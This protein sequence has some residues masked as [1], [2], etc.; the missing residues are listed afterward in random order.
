MEIRV[1]GP[2]EVLAEG[3]PLALPAGRARIV[4][5]VLALHAGRTVS[6]DRLIEAAWGEDSPA[7]ARA[8]VQALVSALRR[9][10]AVADPRSQAIETHNGGYALRADGVRTDLASF[11][12]RIRQGRAVAA[13]GRHGEAVGLFRAALAL[14]RGPAFGGFSSRLLEAEAA[15]CEEIRLAVLEECI[16]VELDL[17]LPTPN[18]DLMTELRAITV[19]HPLR[20]SAQ[21]LRMIA[22]HRAGRPAEALTAFHEARRALADELGVEPG[23][24]LRALYQQILTEDPGLAPE[25]AD[26]P[27]Q[28]GSLA[29][30]CTLFGRERDITGL[31][32]LVLERR[33]VTL[34]GPPGVGK[35][36]LALAGATKAAGRLSDGVYVVELDA[37]TGPEL[38]PSAV[39][40][41]LGI[42]AGPGRPV[43]DALCGAL[44]PRHALLV[45]D[46]CEHLLDACAELADL[47]LT[48][49]PR[50]HILATSREA[51]ALPDEVIQPVGPLDVPP[52]DTMEA[53]L[54]SPAGQM[55]LDRVAARRPGF[56]MTDE[57]QAEL[58]ARI[59]RAVEGLPLAVELVAA[60]LR[61]YALAEVAARL[62][63]Q[64]RSLSR[65]RATPD[66]HRSLEAAIA[67]SHR[68][69]SPGE[70]RV[71]ARL[72]AFSGGFTL[73]AAQAV[74]ADVPAATVQP[75]TPP[76]AA[77][78]DTT[79]R[80]LVD[81]SLLQ[82]SPEDEPTRYRLLEP[83]REFAREQLTLHDEGPAIRSRHAAYFR[84][85]AEHVQLSDDA[86]GDG[87]NGAE[88]RSI[89]LR[90]S[91]RRELPNL[92]AGLDWSFGPGDLDDGLR[93]V[94][95]MSWIWVGLPGEGLQWVERALTRLGSA[96]PTVRP[97]VL[98]AAGLIHL[99]TDL[100][101]AA[102][103]G[104]LSVAAHHLELAEGVLAAHEDREA[105]ATVRWAQAELAYYRGDP[106]SA[107]ALSAAALRDT[108]VGHDLFATVCRRAQHARNLQAAGDLATSARLLRTVLR[109]CLD[110]GLWMPAVDALITAARQEADR[111][112]PTRAVTLL[113]AANTL[114]ATTGRHPAPVEHPVLR[115]L[116]G[117]LQERLAAGEHSEAEKHGSAMTAE[118]AI[119]HALEASPPAW[120]S[121]PHALS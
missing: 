53:V 6:V 111:G 64:M 29:S 33:M 27:R 48:R 56:A 65:R 90:R 94:G 99:S 34:V 19:A 80:D 67:W 14:W 115:A 18:M 20:E 89:R 45:L 35:T 109:A 91:L 113:S 52:E 30:R 102:A 44:A 96:P 13:A 74:A 54:R 110:K 47:L 119:R 1:L 55:F 103:L 88:H 82:A 118:Q 22:L 8:Q 60:Q 75:H 85:M 73:A 116:V 26:R 92:R 112:H 105:L 61:T 97:Q 32:G 41:A 79:V 38:V 28:A 68:L 50:L 3:R 23:P 5:A 39:A 57:A 59:C 78:V 36:Q 108:A 40:G 43:M 120:T 4:L 84:E 98:Y 101:R 86:P 42:P 31:V 37:V 107:A 117:R 83:I 87:R 10:L 11:T 69:L 51:L 114:R 106:H 46:N 62:P 72:S 16:G 100:T 17:G 104:D 24:A 121:P 58:V 81:R 25:G 66:R 95:A 70:Q 15:Q 93:L 49:C 71:F 2:L 12:G 63:Q 76:H 77:A 21:R 7:T 9:A